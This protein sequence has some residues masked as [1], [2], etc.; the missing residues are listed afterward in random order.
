MDWCNWTLFFNIH[1]I[2][3]FIFIFQ[4]SMRTSRTITLKVN[5]TVSADLENASKYHS[6]FLLHFVRN[7]KICWFNQQNNICPEPGPFQIRDIRN[8]CFRKRDTTRKSENE[9]STGAGVLR[10]KPASKRQHR[11]KFKRCFHK[12]P[13]FQITLQS[14]PNHFPTQFH[15]CPTMLTYLF[16]SNRSP[17]PK[18][19][20]IIFRFPIFSLTSSMARLT[21]GRC[22]LL[23]NLSAPRRPRCKKGWLT[24]VVRSVIFEAFAQPF[25]LAEPQFVRHFFI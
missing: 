6:K 15:S 14:L 20:N 5:D 8:K 10:I 25:Q 3:Y 9:M 23:A 2:I 24:R 13:F 1:M 18:Y 7:R 12:E 11:S 22:P 16:E 19:I 4:R 17:I 21:S